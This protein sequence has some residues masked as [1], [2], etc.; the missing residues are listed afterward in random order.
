M[1]NKLEE[2]KDEINEE[3]GWEDENLGLDIDEQPENLL[4]DL[5]KDHQLAN[6]GIVVQSEIDNKNIS[7]EIKENLPETVIKVNTDKV[8]E[9]MTNKEDQADNLENENRKS[10]L[11]VEE[12][13]E[14]DVE[15][16]TLKLEEHNW[17]VDIDIK[18]EINEDIKNEGFESQEL[19]QKNTQNIGVQEE[20]QNPIKKEDEKVAENPET[21][22]DEKHS[23]N[24]ETNGKPEETK[25][26]E[27]EVMLTREPQPPQIIQENEEDKAEDPIVRIINL[28]F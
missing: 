27:K 21:T 26:I 23:E 15:I 1:S 14:E 3:K 25:S 17:E 5:D 4:Q 19:T 28:L 24:S 9:S 6:N 16:E 22:Q 20:N 7:N 8:E 12:E 18:Q 10:D 11:F 13:L 2:D